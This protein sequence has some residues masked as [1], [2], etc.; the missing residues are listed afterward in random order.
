MGLVGRCG[1]LQ[2]TPLTAGPL[3][4]WERLELSCC[5]SLQRLTDPA[6]GVGCNHRARQTLP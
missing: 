1:Q 6:K 3:H 2:T 4:R 5:V